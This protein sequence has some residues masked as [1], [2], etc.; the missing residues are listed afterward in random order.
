MEL[1]FHSNEVK[2]MLHLLSEAGRSFLRAFGGS[3]IILI[4]GLLAAPDLNGAVALGIAALIASVAAGIKAVQVFIPQLTFAKLFPAKYVTYAL[5]TDSFVRA[6]L[7]ALTVSLTGWLAMPALAFDKSVIVGILV[8]A[9]TAGL[10]AV[11]SLFTPGEAPNPQSGLQT[12]AP[13]R[14]PA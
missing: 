1:L 14:K 4:P 6:F 5:W 11:Q 9:V 12:P 3:L 10:R 8:G 2:Y 13:A 7:A